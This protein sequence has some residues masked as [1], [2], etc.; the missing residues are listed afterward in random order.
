[1]H[2]WSCSKYLTLAYVIAASYAT[3][4]LSWE[5]SGK[6]RNKLPYEIS[7]LSVLF[8]HISDCVRRRSTLRNPLGFGIHTQEA[9]V[10]AR[11]EKSRNLDVSLSVHWNLAMHYFALA[12][13]TTHHGH[14]FHTHSAQR[15]PCC[16][17]FVVACIEE[18]WKLCA[19]CFHC[20]RYAT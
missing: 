9:D 10:I 1:M 4:L 18:V 8:M 2:I 7:F 14:H 16:L 19:F 11:W 13:D 6:Y 3:E 20:E 5:K 17:V 15:A 12:A